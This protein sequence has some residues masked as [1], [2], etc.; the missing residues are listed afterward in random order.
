MI[1]F[2]FILLFAFPALCGALEI[3]SLSGRVNDYAG[4]LS[5]AAV[6]TLE[7]RLAELEQSDSTQVV[8]L[9]VPTIDGENI[10]QFGI[11]VAEAWRIG[12]KGLDNGAILLIAKQERKVRIEVG[13]GLEGK[14]TDLMAGRI[15]RDVI[16][17]RF[18]AQDFDGG[19][20]AG[21]EAI[22]ATVK[23]EYQTRQRDIRQGRQGFHPSVTLL[24]FL[25]VGIV[26]L[27][28]ISRIFGGIAGAAG[29]PIAAALSFSGLS[30]AV[31]GV[32]AVV[33]FA[34]GLFIAFLFG[35]GGGGRGGGGWWI[36]GPPG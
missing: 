30:M 18:K 25:L 19:V 27:G 20:L 26:F 24:L 36:G 5:P 29:L 35:S 4:M 22:A 33:G 23:G 13:R 10:E 3:P 16:T 17:P 21:V 11:R 9:T 6:Q 14:L 32:L 2:L 31:L 1:R 8:V 28:S 34:V 7:Q 12:Q 15:I